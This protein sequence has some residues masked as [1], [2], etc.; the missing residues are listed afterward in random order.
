M[1]VGSY[2]MWVS[3]IHFVQRIYTTINKI[4]KWTHPHNKVQCIHIHG[5]SRGPNNLRTTWHTAC[6]GQNKIT[7]LTVQCFTLSTQQS[8]FYHK[9]RVTMFCE[10]STTCITTF[11]TL[12]MIKTIIYINILQKMNRKHVLLIHY[13]TIL[14][15]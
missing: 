2:Y 12:T 1:C 11:N 7:I 4:V 13:Q 8:S 3:F 6:V 15:K 5:V 10:F 14:Y 9:Y